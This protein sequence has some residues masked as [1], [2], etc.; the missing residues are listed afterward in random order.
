MY[1]SSHPLG[2]LLVP[3]HVRVGRERVGVGVEVG[4]LCR[5]ESGIHVPA[6][7]NHPTPGLFMALG[8]VNREVKQSPSDYILLLVM[9]SWHTCKAQKWLVARGL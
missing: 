8:Q 6:R 4:H 3:S 7:D 2:R 1:V 5:A 9:G